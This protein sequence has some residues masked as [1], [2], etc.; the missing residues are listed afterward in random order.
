MLDNP[1]YSWVKLKV[2]TFGNKKDLCLSINFC[3][4]NITCGVVLITLNFD[5]E[6]VNLNCNLYCNELQMVL[7]R[8]AFK[9]KWSSILVLQLRD[10]YIQ[11]LIFNHI[12]SMMYDLC[13]NYLSRRYSHLSGNFKLTRGVRTNSSSCQQN[14]SIKKHNTRSTP[15]QL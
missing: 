7:R 15:I 10:A 5:L 14:C 11:L 6:R 8:D 2:W 13:P 12:V 9:L 1:C 4:P 3:L